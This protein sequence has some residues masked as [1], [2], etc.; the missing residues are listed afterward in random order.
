MAPEPTESTFFKAPIFAVHKSVLH[1]KNNVFGVMG[2]VASRSPSLL[3]FSLWEA[4]SA[5]QLQLNQEYVCVEVKFLSGVEVQLRFVSL[6]N[7]TA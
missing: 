2:W 5:N 6:G 4:S 3:P 7:F 1:A